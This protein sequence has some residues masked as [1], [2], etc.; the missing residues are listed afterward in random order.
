M[1]DGL[2]AAGF[3]PTIFFILGAVLAVAAAGSLFSLLRLGLGLPPMLMLTATIAKKIGAGKSIARVHHGSFFEN[4]GLDYEKHLDIDRLICP[5]YSTALAIAST[6]RNPGALA[7]ENFAR[8]EIQM[9]QFPVANDATAIGKPL[10][11][12]SLKPGIRLAAIIRNR[13]E[14]GRASCRERV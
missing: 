9:Q 1:K 6:L 10:S 13:E 14:I 5:E 2:T 11:E 8:G 12:L 4:R 7:I 3:D